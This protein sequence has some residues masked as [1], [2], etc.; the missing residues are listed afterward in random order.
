MRTNPPFFDVIENQGWLS[1]AKDR[2]MAGDPKDLPHIEEE[3]LP[4]VKSFRSCVQA[5]S[6]VGMWPAKLAEH[7]E[8]VYTFEP[9]RELFYCAARNADMPNI[10]RY[11]AALGY[12][13]KAV[14]MSWGSCD[15]LYGGFH[16]KH[17][18]DIPSMRIDDLG[19]TNVDLIYLDIE[20][21][22]LDALMGAETTIAASRPV[23]VLEWKNATFR[24]FGYDICTITRYLQKQEYEF[25][26]EFHKGKDQI[27]KPK[28]SS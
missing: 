13:R 22:E 18:G 3:V 25:V 2:G 26:H 17:G 7:F 6:G 5:G 11:Q 14:D 19:L 21:R 8:N 20:G 28:N 10:Y 15:N 23:I 24:Q 9:N 4:H 16:V 27:W 1:P 12:D